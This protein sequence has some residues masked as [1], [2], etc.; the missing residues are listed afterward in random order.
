MM[1][2]ST[3]PCGSH[4]PVLRLNLICGLPRDFGDPCCPLPQGLHQCSEDVVEHIND[5]LVAHLSQV[6]ADGQID[7]TVGRVGVLDDRGRPSPFRAGLVPGPAAPVLVSLLHVVL[8]HWLVVCVWVQVVLVSG[9]PN[10]GDDMRIVELHGRRER[11]Q[12]DHG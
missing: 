2:R 12:R 10:C 6:V 4:C 5:L 8:T 3:S 9:E 1:Q 7:A 11:G